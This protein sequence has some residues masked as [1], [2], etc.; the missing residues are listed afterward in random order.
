M[1]F[2][3]CVPK[4][5]LVQ[6]MFE[7]FESVS[8]WC[9]QGSDFSEVWRCFLAESGE[10][11]LSKE[12]WG[13]LK[14]D[15]RLVHLSWV[16][17]VTQETDW[18][19]RY[20]QIATTKLA[21][22]WLDNGVN[23]MENADPPAQGGDD[24]FCQRLPMFAMLGSKQVWH[25]IWY[26]YH[27][28]SRF[29]LLYSF[30]FDFVHLANRVWYRISKVP[31]WLV[32]FRT[33]QDIPKVQGCP[34]DRFCRIFA[35]SRPCGSCRA[36]VQWTGASKPSHTSRSWKP[37]RPDGGTIWL[38]N[39]F[40]WLFEFVFRVYTQRNCIQVS[41]SI[42]TGAIFLSLAPEEFQGFRCLFLIFVWCHFLQCLTFVPVRQFFLFKNIL[43]GL[44]P[45][46]R[47]LRALHGSVHRHHLRACEHG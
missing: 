26:S 31:K 6:N 24:M 3:L 32:G 1:L 45:L 8:S 11:L 36:M 10:Q 25:M 42:L 21:G 7:Q 13:E 35:S 43:R 29:N 40:C 34:A 27:L 33:V 30:I 17:A 15:K 2:S 37:R 12:C 39:V 18:R 5:G 16:L 4:S 14:S 41:Y 9:L 44:K 22:M 28:I 47:C 20:V 19:R 23:E 46:L 38:A